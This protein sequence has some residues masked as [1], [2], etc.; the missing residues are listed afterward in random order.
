ML[1]LI[2]TCFRQF[3]LFSFSSWAW[4]SKSMTYKKIPIMGQKSDRLTEPNLSLILAKG[5]KCELR[6]YV[7]DHRC[8]MKARNLRL[9]HFLN[10]QLTF[11]EVES[12]AEYSPDAT[13][14]SASSLWKNWEATESRTRVRPSAAILITEPLWC[15][16][17]GSKNSEI[18]VV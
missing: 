12:S 17:S 16:I 10:G 4:L 13:G 15:L 11:S 14:L 5:H 7:D 1:W 2:I 9:L 3:N 8:L 6:S 18:I